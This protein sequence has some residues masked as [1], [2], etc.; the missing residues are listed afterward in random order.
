ML[1]QKNSIINTNYFTTNYF[2]VLCSSYNC[3]HFL[4]QDLDLDMWSWTCVDDPSTSRVMLKGVPLK[5]SRGEGPKETQESW[6]PC[7]TDDSDT[8]TDSPVSPPPRQVTPRRR[9]TVAKKKRGAGS[10]QFKYVYIHLGHLF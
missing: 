9:V 4:T 5:A 2:N 8:E 6:F 3:L 7:L 10:A 1:Q